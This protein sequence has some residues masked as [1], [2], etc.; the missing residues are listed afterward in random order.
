MSSFIGLF[1]DIVQ[2]GVLAASII[3]LMVLLT[4]FL[5]AWYTPRIPKEGK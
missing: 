4:I 5:W 2:Y 3:T 1:V